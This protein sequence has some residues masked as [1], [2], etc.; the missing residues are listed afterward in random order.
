MARQFHLKGRGFSGR[1]IRV[2]PLDPDVSERNLL[3]AAKL[4]GEE[5]SGLEIKKIEWRNG[6]KQFITHFSEK[7]ADPLAEG[8]KWRKVEPGQLDIMGEF[9]TTKDIQFIE[10]QF[11]DYHEVMPAEVADIV[12]KAIDLAED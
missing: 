5:A 2:K 4:A 12:G 9:F 10:A 7:C 11:R 6:M 1:A 8:V 3:A